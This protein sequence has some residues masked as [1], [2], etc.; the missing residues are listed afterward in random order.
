MAGG[1]FACNGDVVV[2]DETFHRHT[3]VPVVAETV[4]EDGVGNL[5]AD[6]VRVAV[7]DLFAGEEHMNQSFLME[8]NATKRNRLKILLVRCFGFWIAN[9]AH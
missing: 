1:E 3:A 9:M 5:V 2:L 7:A 8:I 6:F 4:G